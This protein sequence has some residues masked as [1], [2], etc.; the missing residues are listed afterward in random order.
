MF[1]DV[2]HDPQEGKKRQTCPLAMG[3]P[4]VNCTYVTA[5]FNAAFEQSSRGGGALLRVMEAEKSTSISPTYS[6]PN[7]QS[8]FCACP[9]LIYLTLH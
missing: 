4:A 3:K 8:A 9:H 2:R 7:R 1:H 6:V 5:L